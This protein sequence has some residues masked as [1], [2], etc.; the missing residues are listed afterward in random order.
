MKITVVFLAMMLGLSMPAFSDEPDGLSPQQTADIEQLLRMTGS[1]S[2]AQMSQILH[3]ARP[4]IPQR[5]LDELPK[6]VQA[7]RDA[8]GQLEDIF[9][10]LSHEHFTAPDIKELL[11]FYSSPAGQKLLQEAPQLVSES[12]QAGQALGHKVGP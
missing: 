12:M 3:Q 4:D 9:V 7:V 6:D 11:R 2:A 10:Q 5:V 8:N 1:L